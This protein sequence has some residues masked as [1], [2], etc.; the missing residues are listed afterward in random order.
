MSLEIFRK[1]S[2]VLSMRGACVVIRALIRRTVAF[3]SATIRA[4]LASSL[5]RSGAVCVRHEA[6]HLL[7]DL[8]RIDRVDL[9]AGVRQQSLGVLL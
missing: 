2:N 4:I 1:F 5:S 6:F 3:S 7:A 8:L 9:A